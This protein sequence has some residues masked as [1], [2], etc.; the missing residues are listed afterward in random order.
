[1]IVGFQL[2]P[3]FN[4]FQTFC[5]KHGSFTLDLVTMMLVNK[6]RM[7]FRGVYQWTRDSG[8]EFM[9]WKLVKRIDFTTIS[10]VEMD[11]RYIKFLCPVDEKAT[12]VNYKNVGFRYE[13]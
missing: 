7:M 8:Y 11:G 3:L 4:K 2:K 13:E 10:H 5:E 12:G 6:R 9:P 1:M